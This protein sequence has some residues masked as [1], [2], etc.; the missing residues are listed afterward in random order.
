MTDKTLSLKSEQN[1]NT[2]R[3]AVTVRTP[4]FPAGKHHLFSVNEGLP[5]DVL[6]EASSIQNSIL[7]TLEWLALHADQPNIDMPDSRLF[8]SLS[9][10]AEAVDATLRAAA[11]GA[12][13]ANRASAAD[14]NQQSEE[15]GTEARS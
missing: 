8:W 1:P 13:K 14:C 6:D 5:L 10:L 12:L 7:G 15:V 2:L 4:F 11:S 9:Y 3:N